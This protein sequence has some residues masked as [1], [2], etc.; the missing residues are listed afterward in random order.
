M[1]AQAGL[2]WVNMRLNQNLLRFL[3]FLIIMAGIL[4]YLGTK[5]EAFD[6]EVMVRRK[7]ARPEGAVLVRERGEKAAPASAKGPVVTAKDFF[8]EARLERDRVRSEEIQ[9][10]K[11]LASDD[12]VSGD[13][14]I[15]AQR[16]LLALSNRRA[17]EAE[18]EALLRAKGYERAVVFLNERGA[19]VIVWL[20]RVTMEDAS[21]LA[22]M[23]AAATGVSI[24]D[25]RIVPYQK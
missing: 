1:K 21:R 7:E 22:D 6:R 12:K 10:L 24:A 20:D 17:R 25:V 19:V 14:R 2:R 15:K 13:I 11:E 18:A 4:W 16:D 3:A 5:W 9:T 23:V 8:I